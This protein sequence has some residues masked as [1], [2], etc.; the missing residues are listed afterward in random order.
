MKAIFLDVDGTL[1]PFGER[2]PPESAIQAI[3]KARKAGHRVYINTGR[4]RQEV[5]KELENIGFDGIICSNSLYV[6][7]DGKCLFQKDMDKELV[8]EISDFFEEE[9]IG[10]FLEGQ[11]SVKASK[12]FFEHVSA[13]FGSEASQKFKTGFPSIMEARITYDDVAK[14][15]FLPKEDTI[16]KLKIRFEKKCQINSW[17]LLG[18]DRG[19]GEVTL[20]EASKASGVKLIMKR[21][22]LKKEDTYAFGDS[23]GDLSMIEFSGT[24]V[25]MGNSE[26][27]LKDYSDYV[28][29]SI[30][31]D[32]ILRAFENFNL[33]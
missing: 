7:E 21:H 28:T 9:K 10:Y 20:K 11:K 26:Q 16:E 25:A 18:S 5:G 31:N 23:L 14:I 27:I 33:L 3:Q 15:N 24:G 1:V 29:S 6:E 12:L 8:K 19:M 32:G 22:G 13:L 17:S 4:C 30:E 2:L